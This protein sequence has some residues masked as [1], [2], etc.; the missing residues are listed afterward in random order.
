MQ[1]INE[2]RLNQLIM[3]FTDLRHRPKSLPQ[4]LKS[5]KNEWYLGLIKR[6]NNID[7]LIY[8]RKDAHIGIYE[9]ET[10][11]NR[12]EMCTQL[13]DCP[14]THKYYKGIKKMYIDKGVTAEDCYASSKYIK[15]IY[16]P[17]INRKIKEIRKA[18]NESAFFVNEAMIKPTDKK[19]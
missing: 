12:I 11:G 13:G 4:L 14:K 9:M 18:Q 3:P 2:G 17:E 10:I 8:L 15:D 19:I 1:N 5:R 16:L 6:T 7:D